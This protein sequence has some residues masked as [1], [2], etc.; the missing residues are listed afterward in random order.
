MQSVDLGFYG[1]RVAGAGRPVVQGRVVQVVGIVVESVLP[2]ARIGDVYEL[3]TGDDTVISEVVGFR[4][5]RAILMPFGNLRGV[6]VGT[7]VIPLGGVRAAPVGEELLGRVLDAFGRPLDGGAALRC[8]G[9]RSVHADPPRPLERDPKCCPIHVGIRAIDALAPCARGQRLG[10]FASPGLGKSMLLGMM[11]RGAE[12]DRI[13]IALVGERGREVGQFVHG[14]LGPDGLRRAVVVAATSDRPPLERIRAAWYATAIAEHFRDRG[15]HVLLVMDSLT[16][17]A[18][19]QREVGLAAGEPPTT[20]GFTPSVFAALPRL[21]ERVGPI[22][23]GSITGFYTVL[24]EGDDLQDP[25]AEAARSLLDGH[26]QLDRELAERGHFPAI[27]PLRS[28]SRVALDVM[29]PAHFE[30]ART[31]REHL[32]VLQEARELLSVGAYRAGANPRLDAALVLR[33]RIAAYLRQAID[34]KAPFAETLRGLLA[35]ASQG[36]TEHGARTATPAA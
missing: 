5:E 17:F 12:C 26:I 18:M 8:R 35:L 14:T 29:E 23:K 13:V 36:D 28:V 4:D 9:R 30:A 20:R 10:I 27:D 2:A 15:E 34:E 32:A 16:R 7:K 11:A 24:T 33:E 19:A 6:G 31:I 3:N 1:R 21:I 22:G 25:V